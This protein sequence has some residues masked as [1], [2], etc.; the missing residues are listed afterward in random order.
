MEPY[1]LFSVETYSCEMTA[2]ELPFAPFRK[3]V[4]VVLALYGL[5]EAAKVVAIAWLYARFRAFSPKF[6][7][8]QAST[9][10]DSNRIFDSLDYRLGAFVRKSV[11]APILLHMIGLDVFAQLA[12]AKPSSLDTWLELFYEVSVLLFSFSIFAHFWSPTWSALSFRPLCF[13]GFYGKFPSACSLDYFCAQHH[14]DGFF[15]SEHRKCP[16]SLYF[17]LIFFIMLTVFADFHLNQFLF[18]DHAGAERRTGFMQK[19]QPV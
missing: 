16:Q 14:Q 12:F 7:A 15:G 1:C 2:N 3:W 6:N 11:F 17:T 18:F 10:K 5:K 8:K 13:S 4:L 9:S 19:T